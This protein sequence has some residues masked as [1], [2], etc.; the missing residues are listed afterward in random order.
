M[1]HVTGE[2]KVQ[3]NATRRNT[4]IL[5]SPVALRNQ[6]RAQIRRMLS[7]VLPAETP[8]LSSQ[9][10]DETQLAMAN[11]M[12]SG[13]SINGRKY[14]FGDHVQY[15]DLV[16]RNLNRNREAGNAA[17]FKVGTVNRFYTFDTPSGAQAGFVEL[18]DRPVLETS[19]SMSALCTGCAFVQ[20]NVYISS[21][22]A[23]YV[24]ILQT[25]YVFVHS[26]FTCHTIPLHVPV[27]C[28]AGVLA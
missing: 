21:P 25:V 16:N 19:R 15:T 10:P 12:L 23:Q 11:H 13:V 26:L 20:E 27:P 5:P 1:H 8:F 9:L 14:K 3:Y 4:K 24:N 18:T 22:C 6:V 28:S 2:Y 17:A 7:A